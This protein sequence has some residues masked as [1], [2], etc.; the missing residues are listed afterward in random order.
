[1]SSR[2]PRSA[3]AFKVGSSRMESLRFAPSMTQPMGLP[4]RSVAT[5]RL[6]SPI[7]WVID[8]ANRNDSILL[9][10]TLKAVADRGLLLDIETLHLDRGYDSTATIERC[11]R[12]G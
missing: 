2:S 3:T 8:G 10:P 9:E 4:N 1:M 12:L 7:G 6:G 11:H 5:D